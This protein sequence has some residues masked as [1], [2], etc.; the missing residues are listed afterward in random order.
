MVLFTASNGVP[1]NVSLGL[2]GYEDKLTAWVRSVALANGHSVRV[3]SA[4]DFVIHT[5]VAGRPIGLRDV[6]RIIA[7]R[8]DQTHV[9]YVRC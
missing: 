8:Q 5:C 6:E 1:V 4:E 9:M 2:P 7:R 3:C